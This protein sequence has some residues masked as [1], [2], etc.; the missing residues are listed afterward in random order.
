MFCDAHFHSS[1][2]PCPDTGEPAQTAEE[3]AFYLSCAAGP[4]DWR[5]LLKSPGITPYL[6]IHPEKIDSRWT[7]HLKELRTLLE[8]NPRAGVGECGVDRRFYKTLPRSLQEEVLSAQIRLAEEFCRPVS[9]HQ[10]GAP[11]VLADLLTDLKV[12]VPMMI[13]GFNDSQEILQRYLKLGLYISLGPGAHWKKKEFL[14]TASRI[15]E[16]RLLLETDWPYISLSQGEAPPE[17]YKSCLESHYSL[18]SRT[19]G[20]D[21]TRLAGLVKRNGTLFKN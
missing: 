11:G 10:V 2:T 9:L 4:A 6:G 14:T 20:I 17:S 3:G 21:I 8:K 12:K 13:H 7:D 18:V 15:P 1:H 16:N 19:L 5:T